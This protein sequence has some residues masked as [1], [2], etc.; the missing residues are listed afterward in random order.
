MKA[1]RLPNPE[2]HK[3]FI[4][5]F[6]NKGDITVKFIPGLKVPAASLRN[7]RATV[8]LKEPLI[9]DLEDNMWDSNAYHEGSHLLP[10]LQF[11]YDALEYVQTELEKTIMNIIVDNMCERARHG[12]Y[13]GRDRS[14]YNGRYEYV[15]ENRDIVMQRSHPSMSALY[16][17]DFRDRNKWQ[18]FFPDMKGM[19]GSDYYLPFIEALDLSRRIPEVMEVQNA[20]DLYELVIEITK[21]A[22]QQPPPPTPQ[23]GPGDDNSDDDSGDSQS[24]SADSDSDGTDSA[25]TDS[26][27]GG[28]D[29]SADSEGEDT[30]SDDAGRNNQGDDT[31]ADSEEEQEGDSGDEQTMGSDETGG[32]PTDG[33][34]NLDGHGDDSG[35]DRAEGS[36]VTG[37]GDDLEESS[38]TSNPATGD[39]TGSEASWDPID[40]DKNDLADPDRQMKP[41]NTYVYQDIERDRYVPIADYNLVEVSRLRDRPYHRNEITNHSDGT[42]LTRSIQ[43]YLRCM[44]RDTYEY[45]MER[46]RIHAKHLPRIF[47]QDRRPKIFKQKH[48]HILRTDTAVS[49]LVDCSSSMESTRFTLAAA[50]ALV[51]SDTLRELQITHEILGFTEEKKRIVIYAFKG[52]TELLNH[53]RTLDRLSKEFDMGYTPD[54]ESIVY[55]ANRLIERPEENKVLMVLCDGQPMGSF[56]GSGEWYLKQ[57][58]QTIEKSGEMQL[59]GIGIQHTGVKRFYKNHAIVNDLAKDLEPVMIEVLTKSLL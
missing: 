58:C 46:G 52:F 18:G 43:K 25:D 42:A 22:K 15:M 26:D 37:D 2:A 14:L 28:S 48:Q 6:C 34:D 21:L 5:S 4:V 55:A 49:L 8:L 54:G 51:V 12:K 19:E 41:K 53:D 39:G 44:A 23:G 57:V 45:G 29:E 9:T 35:E 36:G 16:V 20:R 13:K 30:D 33:S 24:D 3:K 31:N 50:S 17:V 40:E 10:E 56:Q 38:D 27:E 7:G 11:T 1:K 47:T 59:I 32:E